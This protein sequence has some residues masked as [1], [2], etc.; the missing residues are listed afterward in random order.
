M[1]LV[2][3]RVR[4]ARVT[5]DG[6]EVAA[7][8]PGMLILCGIGRN[9]T[10]ADRAYLARKTANLRIFDDREGKMNL[11]PK[12]V[13]ADILVVSQFTLLADCSR[14]NRPSYLEAAPPEEAEAGVEDFVGRLRAE[15][16]EVQTGI[17]RAHMQVEL[18]NDGPVTIIM[19]STGRS[20]P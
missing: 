11:G 20:S 13:G 10:P 16:F 9:D 3:Q 1:K 19:E 17:F 5:V 12:E 18:L 15:G 6:R 7:I 4:H 14:G 2:I 8:G